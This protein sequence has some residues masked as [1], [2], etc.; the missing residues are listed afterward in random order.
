MTNPTFRVIWSGGMERRGECPGLAGDIQRTGSAIPAAEGALGAARVDTAAHLRAY[1]IGPHKILF[2]A[3]MRPGGP[4][5]RSRFGDT[6]ERR[7]KG[8]R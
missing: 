5:Y 3:A 6:P 1:N 8:G 4:E 2:G 7:P